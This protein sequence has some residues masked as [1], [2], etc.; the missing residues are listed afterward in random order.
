MKKV[1]KTVA[2]IC[3][4]TLIAA[5]FY[6]CNK[7]GANNQEN[8]VKTVPFF[9]V[10]KG[11]SIPKDIF[12][13]KPVFGDDVEVLF[14]TENQLKAEWASES[15]D[16]SYKYI[17]YDFK[18]W[19]SKKNDAPN[20]KDG[21]TKIP[22]DLNEGAGGKWIY[23]YFKKT[24]N[25]GE[26]LSEINVKAHALPILNTDNLLYWKTGTEFGSNSWTDLNEGA[27]GN[28]IKLQAMRTASSY[29]GEIITEIAIVSSTN[30]SPTYSSV[31]G[32]W[33]RIPGD[34]NKGAGGK[35]I[36]L[37]YKSGTIK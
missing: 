13:D 21:Y 28:Y 2:V 9:E 35:Y 6:A 11:D 37:F 5:S 30:S 8:E 22:V 18:T 27:G 29:K 23:L 36:Y 20:S 26:G 19:V 7:E 16:K 34:L 3:T 1:F 31:G 4:S 24:N 32:G 12:R 17:H 15:W 33:N 14:T 10:E 25:I